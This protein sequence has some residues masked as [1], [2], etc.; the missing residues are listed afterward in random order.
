MSAY[1]KRQPVVFSRPTAHLPLQTP[2]ERSRQDGSE[3]RQTLEE[4]LVRVKP[5]DGSVER[6]GALGQ[7]E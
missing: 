1:W 2:D 4:C 3:L 7:D 6:T 5:L